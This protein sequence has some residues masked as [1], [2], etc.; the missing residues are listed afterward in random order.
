MLEVSLHSP[1]LGKPLSH[2]EAQE[3]ELVASI[4]VDSQVMMFIFEHHKADFK[5]LQDDHGV[6]VTWEKGASSIMVRPSD[7]IS[8][9]RKKFDEACKAIASFQQEFQTTTSYILPE[10]WKA[11]VDIFMKNASVMKKK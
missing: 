6:R 11:V 5:Q 7:K 3:V 8:T 1:F 4:P 9:N 10:A 2:P